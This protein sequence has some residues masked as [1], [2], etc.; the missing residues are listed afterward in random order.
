M[1]C[2]FSYFC[3]V[4]SAVLF[5]AAIGLNIALVSAS[6]LAPLEEPFASWNL[7][8]RCWYHWLMQ[9]WGFSTASLIALAI[10]LSLCVPKP[11][12]VAVTCI[13]TWKYWIISSL[14]LAWAFARLIAAPV[15]DPGFSFRK[16]GFSQIPLLSELAVWVA[17][18]VGS[19]IIASTILFLFYHMLKLTQYRIR[20][21]DKEICSQCG[22]S[23]K[24]LVLPRCPECGHWS[25]SDS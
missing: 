13:R 25:G 9:I 24:G 20:L 14:V 4:K 17:G 7:Y 18:P 22:Y 19:G 6:V 3:E 2:R 1:K 11:Y 23:L 15:I 16:S 12:G 21:L 5:A 8:L 10:T